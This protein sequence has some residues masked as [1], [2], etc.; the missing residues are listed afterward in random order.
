MRRDPLVTS[1]TRREE[2]PRASEVSPH[3][4]RDREQLD[5]AFSAA[6]EELRR[7][8][9]AVRRHDPRAT[10]SATTLVNEAWLKLA[11]S[12]AVA[13][14]TPLHFRRIAAR[15]M[16][17][18]LVESARRRHAGKRGGDAVMVTLDGAVAGTS[19]PAELLALN[20]ALDA[21]ARVSERQAAVVEYRFF[22]G[23]DVAEVGRLLDISPATVLRDWRLARAWLAHALR[24]DPLHA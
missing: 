13:H 9:A 3:V 16:R 7:L 5:A 20:D 14:T 22:G 11:H 8:A 23:A 17:Q 6:Y 15:A 10:A 18:L 12:P 21:L 2:S 24:G 1:S 19:T 4:A